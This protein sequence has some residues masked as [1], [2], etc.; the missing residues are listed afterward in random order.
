[1]SNSPAKGI[2]IIGVGKSE[3]ERQIVDRAAADEALVV[4]LVGKH[5]EQVEDGTGRV[6]R[7]QSFSYDGEGQWETNWIMDF[8]R[9]GIRRLKP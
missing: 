7:S 6:F 4:K 2:A 3:L 5:P 9:T 1:M 8:S